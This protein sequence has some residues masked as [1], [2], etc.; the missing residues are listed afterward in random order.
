MN[1]ME[2]SR[3]H[4]AVEAINAI[5]DEQGIGRTELARRLGWERM[6]VVR[7]LTPGKYHSE[8]T[9]S[10]LERIA[11]V[12][13]VPVS[14]LLPTATTDSPATVGAGGRGTGASVPAGDGRQGTGPQ[15][16]GPTRTEP[17]PGGAS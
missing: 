16:P 8:L 15:V 17:T 12:L 14:Q 10:E 1:A 2:L 9:I 4:P 6:Q 5:L 13:G 11:A 7:R 3:T